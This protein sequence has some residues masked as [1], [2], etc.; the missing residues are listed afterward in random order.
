[1]SIL[2]SCS[3]HMMHD[4]MQRYNMCMQEYSCASNYIVVLHLCLCVRRSPVYA[5][6]WRILHWTTSNLD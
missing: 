5:S 3:M 4:L 2:Y 6:H 1:M